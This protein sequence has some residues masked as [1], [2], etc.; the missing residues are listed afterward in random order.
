MIEPF[1]V[2]LKRTLS[3]QHPLNQILRFHCRELTVPNTFGVPNL[4]NENG[5][6]DQLF[7]YG[8]NG[9]FRMLKDTY[10]LSTWEITDYRGNIEVGQQNSPGKKLLLQF[11]IYLA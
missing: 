8:N 11:T 4:V 5:L 9:S 6:T 2:I 3:K 1:C 10:P 7:A